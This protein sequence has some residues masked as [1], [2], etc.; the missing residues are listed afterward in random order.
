ML[1]MLMYVSARKRKNMIRI[2]STQVNVTEEEEIDLMMILNSIEKIDGNSQQI[3]MNLEEKDLK[4][5]KKGKN[6]EEI[7]DINILINVNFLVIA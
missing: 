4:N 5:V 3:E 7:D 2:T 6:V 1:M